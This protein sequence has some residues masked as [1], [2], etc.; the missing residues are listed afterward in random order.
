MT[1]TPKT[2]A[3]I[4]SLKQTLRA[5]VLHV[6]RVQQAAQ[7][8][9]T[10]ATAEMATHEA[11]LLALLSVE[12]EAEAPPARVNGRARPAANN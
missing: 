10:A 3:S 8:V 5:Y 9:L 12:A 4:A 1:T 6:A 7:A 11:E 2:D